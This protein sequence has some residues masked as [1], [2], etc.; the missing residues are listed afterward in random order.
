[1]RVTQR[2]NPHFAFDI[3]IGEVANVIGTTYIYPAGLTP[4]NLHARNVVGV[5]L[6]LRY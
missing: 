5:G 6:S 3:G 4:V 2:D 1:M